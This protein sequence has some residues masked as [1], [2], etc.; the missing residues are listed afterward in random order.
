[1]SHALVRI[2]SS[3]SDLATRANKQAADA[4]QTGKKAVMIAW[5]CGQTLI[6]ARREVGHGNFG[7]W[8]EENFEQGEKTAYRYVK[9]AEVLNLSELTN[10]ED[11]TSAYREAEKQAKPKIRTRVLEFIEQNP[12]C[13]DNDIIES[14]QE[15]QASV[16]GRRAELLRDGLIKKSGESRIAGRAQATYRRSDVLEIPSE[17][18]PQVDLQEALRSA[19]RCKSVTPEYIANR[20]K[21]PAR[22]VKAALELSSEMTGYKAVK[23]EDGEFA[24][25]RVRIKTDAQQLR[26]AKSI[27]IEGDVTPV[28]H[29]RETLDTLANMIEGIV[30]QYGPNCKNHFVWKSLSSDDRDNL[31]FLLQSAQAKVS[32]KFPMFLEYLK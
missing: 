5:E 23:T 29:L 6:E 20:T 8:L 3:L 13:T 10:L 1:M 4:L 9:M 7:E 19:A 18:L 28:E 21:I 25:H 24:I 31:R 22:T 2:H 14:L 17:P 11:L 16:R 32:D 26:E 12:D 30:S 15:K 27:K